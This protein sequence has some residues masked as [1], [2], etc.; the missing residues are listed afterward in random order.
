MLLLGLGRREGA[1]TRRC[2]GAAVGCA[3][4]CQADQAAQTTGRRAPSQPRTAARPSSRNAPGLS[5]PNR[6]AATPRSRA[7]STRGADRAGRADERGQHRVVPVA[8]GLGGR[9]GPAEQ[10]PA[11]QRRGS[12]AARRGRQL[13]GDQLAQREHAADRGPGR[14]AEPGREP[15]AVAAGGGQG[16]GGDADR[17]ARAGGGA[18]RGGPQQDG[19]R[20]ADRGRAP[21]LGGRG[22]GQGGVGDHPVHQVRH[23]VA[24]PV[25]R[26]PGA[27][28]AHPERGE[29]DVGGGHRRGPQQRTADRG[30]EPHARA[31]EHPGQR[32]DP[33]AR[34]RSRTAGP[35]RRTGSAARGGCRRRRSRPARPGARTT[36]SGASLAGRPRTTMSR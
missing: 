17:A 14:A 32:A 36:C 28:V 7:P 21:L 25:D 22:R 16:D 3:P 26:R 35:A 5:E 34:P 13:V 27:R 11:A 20:G 4:P 10:H 18:E 9:R 15:A 33:D 2:A 19:Q 1:G 8:A 24:H 29:G 31:A 30:R 6:C 12:E 23:G